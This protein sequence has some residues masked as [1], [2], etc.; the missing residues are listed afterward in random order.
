MGKRMDRRRKVK[1]DNVTLHNYRPGAAHVTCDVKHVHHTID[2][3]Q[4]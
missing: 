3:Y 2:L 4:P 1:G